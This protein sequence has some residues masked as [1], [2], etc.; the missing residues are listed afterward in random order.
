MVLDFLKWIWNNISTIKDVF[1]I[2]FT[3][4]AT[5]I[6]VLTYKRARYTILQ[7][8]RTE[9]IK[10]Q[11]DLFI[12]IIDTFSDESKMLMD[13]DLDKIVALNTYK[14]LNQYGYVLNRAE[15][16]KKECDKELVGGLI[17]K[18]EEQLDMLEKPE[19][20]NRFEKGEDKSDT[21]FREKL[22]ENLK[23]G[24]IDIEMI[25]FTKKYDETMEKYKKLTTNTFL[26]KEIKEPLE[27][28]IKNI[29]EDISINLKQ[30]LEEFVLKVYE[31]SKNGEKFSINPIGV[32]NE[33]NQKRHINSKLIEKI[34]E[35]TREYLLIDKKW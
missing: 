16:L 15:S 35:K 26:P 25:Y 4:I 12:E 19:V 7:P 30:T 18:R 27:E 9:V 21:D 17:V 23:N 3:F 6:A 22:Y 20:F 2:I 14:V 34:K 24:K 29:Y 11:T 1:W 28:I 8:L 13:L 32:Y 5:I 33:F 31:K 10:R